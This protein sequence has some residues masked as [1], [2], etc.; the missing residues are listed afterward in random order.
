MERSFTQREWHHIQFRDLPAASAGRSGRSWLASAPT[1][2]ASVV[3]VA[4][5]RS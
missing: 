4:F 1:W 2:S 3:A 5:T